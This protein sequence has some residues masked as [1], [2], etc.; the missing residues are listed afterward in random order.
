V[1]KAAEYAAF[2]IYGMATI[3]T[4]LRRVEAVDTDKICVESVTD[5]KE[6]IKEK[7]K[8]QL[9]SGE[10]SAGTEITPY[11]TPLTVRIKQSK[12]QPTDR[13]TL[14]DTGAFYQGVYVNV[15]GSKVVIESTDS[16]TAALEAKYSEQIFGLNDKFKIE[17]IK[18]SLRPVFKSKIEA[19][20]GLKFN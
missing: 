9:Y 17:Y 5:T 8:E 18:E 10:T 4:V 2:L 14:R 12:G 20:T 11:Y 1:S 6:T 16:K 19:A 15:T 3:L 13:V 7:N